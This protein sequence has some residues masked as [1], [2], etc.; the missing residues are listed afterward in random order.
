MN[1]DIFGVEGIEAEIEIIS[2]AHS[3]MKGFGLKDDNYEIRVN[4]RKIVNYILKDFLSLSPWNLTSL[5]DHRQKDKM[6]KEDFAEKIILS[7]AIRA[8]SF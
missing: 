1:A 3:I 5:K 7:S 6:S 2:L 8:T 4:D